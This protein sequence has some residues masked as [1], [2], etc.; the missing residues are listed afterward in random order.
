[1]VA[2]GVFEAAGR[3]EVIAWRIGVDAQMTEMACTADL[4]G[5]EASTRVDGSADAGA[6]GEHED[7]AAVFGNSGPDFA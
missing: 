5:E 7:I 1:M 6:E 2:D 3:I 4:A